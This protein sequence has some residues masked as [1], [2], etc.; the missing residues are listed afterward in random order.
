M[1]VKG[2]QRLLALER[3]LFEETD[4]SNQ[5]SMKELAEKLKHAFSSETDFDPRAIKRDLEAL[6]EQG[7]EIIINKGIY[8]KA[9]YSH[10]HRLRGQGGDSS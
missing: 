9:L 10:Q 1:E 3:I 5:L 2:S 4:E 6:D 7:F 8:G